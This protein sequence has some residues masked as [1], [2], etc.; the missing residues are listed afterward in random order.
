MT[1]E[2]ASVAITDVLGSSRVAEG[3]DGEG[4]WTELLEDSSGRRGEVVGL[5]SKNS[6]DRQTNHFGGVVLVVFGC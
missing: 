2:L 5:T 1:Y 4:A 3:V 6:G